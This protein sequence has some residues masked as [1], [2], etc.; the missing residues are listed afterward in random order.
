M[1]DVVVPASPKTTIQPLSV[2]GAMAGPTRRHLTQPAGIAD[3][4]STSR[5]AL[6]VSMRV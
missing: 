1:N 3:D 2:T 4:T 5:T 6:P